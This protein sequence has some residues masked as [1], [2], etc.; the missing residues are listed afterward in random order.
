MA[1]P[2][3][4][5]PSAVP[6]SPTELRHIVSN[7]ALTPPRD[8]VREHKLSGRSSQHLQYRLGSRS[9][10]S[11]PSSPTSI[12]SSSS[13]IF[14]RD[15]E[16]LSSPTAQPSHPTNP[17]RIPRGKAT[18]QLDNAVPSVLDSAAT[19]LASPTEEQSISVTAPATAEHS[20]SISGFASPISRLSSR[21]PSP[22]AGRS[23][24]AVMNLPSPSPSLSL[25]LPAASSVPASPPLRPTL[26]TIPTSSTGPQPPGAFTSTSPT[27]TT[28]FFSS[29]RASPTTTAAADTPFPS[30]NDPSPH[31]SPSARQ[32]SPTALSHPPSPRVPTKRLSFMSYTDLLSSTPSST[33]PLSMLTTSA[34][35]A[36]PPPHIPSV[37]GLP[38]GSGGA[39]A[40]AS[41]RNSFY[42][43]RDV[44][45]GR[46]GLLV[47]DVGGEWEREGLGQGLEERLE[48]L[49]G[50]T[51]VGI[52]K[53]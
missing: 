19:V 32:L 31:S 33:L 51:A 36:D 12:H 27:P 40:G 47:D 29:S 52:G 9:P 4:L 6:S 14:E 49:M 34:T 39:S 41:P 28:T 1:S 43:E 45:E 2:T 16:P 37:L 25:P 23:P 30:Q 18:E 21:S 15:I 50:V 24:A 10:S 26:Q 44:R 46:E 13:A 11:I 20:S 53:A 22:V 3:H 7:G 48:S 38:Q 17:H 8:T 42:G 5:S 35:T